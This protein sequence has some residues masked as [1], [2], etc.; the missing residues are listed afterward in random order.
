MIKKISKKRKEQLKE[1]NRIKQELF[2]NDLK[3]GKLYCFLS[4]IRITIPEEMRGYP[5]DILASMIEVHHINGARE[6]EHLFD[7]EEMKPVI[8]TYHSQYHSL[9]SKALLKLLWYNGYLNRI[10]ISH[11]ELYNKEIRK[12]EK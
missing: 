10:K 2:L 8:R 12:H 3:A 11:P 9:S 5:D 7:P 4:N 6:N 1:Y